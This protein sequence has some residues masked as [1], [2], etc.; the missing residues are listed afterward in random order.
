MAL[1]PKESLGDELV[2]RLLRGEAGDGGLENNLLREVQLGYAVSKLRLLLRSD[3]HKVVA[4]GMWIASELGAAARPL[5][6]DI[7]DLMHHPALKVR[8]FALDCVITCARP[9][10]DRA[11]TL[12]LDLLNDAEPAVRWKAMVSVATI[13]ESLLK[14]AWDASGVNEQAGARRKGLELVLNATRSRDN[15]AVTSALASR[16]D[17]LRRYAAAAAARMVHQDPFPLKQAMTS[18]DPMI[19]QFASDMAARAG[20]A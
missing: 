6:A 7:T 16:D 9:E 8:F 3:D 14:A 12:A 15:T 2:S 18:A 10:D 4:A 11:L 17:I 5:F 1:N 20:I 19:K 13:P